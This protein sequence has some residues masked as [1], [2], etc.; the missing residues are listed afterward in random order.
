M[1]NLA[2]SKQPI[3][4][5]GA[6]SWGSALAILLARNGHDVRLWGHESDH[7][8]EMQSKHCNTRYLPGILF[9][10]NLQT[11]SDVSLALE[12]VQDVLVV[13]PSHAFSSLLLRI[14]PFF[15]MQSRLIWGTKGL[16][17]STGQ[18]LHVVAE[19]ILEKPY[20][21]AVLAGPSFAQEVALE[22]PTAI[23]IATENAQLAA[24]MSQYLNNAYFRVY[25]TDDVPGVEI[26]GAVKNILAIAAGF[27][28]A[29]DLGMNAMSALITRGLAEIQRLGIALGGKPSTFMG[30][31]GVGD[32]VLT[33]TG[34][35]SRNRRFGAAIASGKQPAAAL[36][37]I[38]QVVEGL[39]NLSGVYHLA[40]TYQV[41]MPITEQIYHV[42]NHGLSVKEAIG[43]LFA[44]E[45]KAE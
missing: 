37:E 2:S 19:E 25:T 30:L 23:T 5:L 22:K 45:P 39:D 40:Q 36:K 28:D 8:T 16:E 20:P 43:N 12:A 7:I 26:C 18:L 31:A 1:D 15:H 17:P 10:E 4:V 34:S 33:C 24:S 27:V 29:L 32:L 21:L 44:R 42:I 11:Y 35:L 3:A 9:P 38:G 13:V 6:G 41:D 14:K